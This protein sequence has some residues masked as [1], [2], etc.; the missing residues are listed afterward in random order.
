RRLEKRGIALSAG[1]LP[2]A[3]GGSSVTAGGP[4]T[5]LIECVMRAAHGHPTAAA[6]ALANGASTPMFARFKLLSGLALAAGLV[7][8]I[9]AQHPG[10]HAGPKPEQSKSA[11]TPEAKDTSAAKP[12]DTQPPEIAGRV[13]DSDGKPV[14][15]AKVYI[16]YYTPKALP[17][18]DRA[19]TD[20][21]GR[22]KF[23]LKA[24]D[25]DPTYSTTPWRGAFV[26]AKSDGYGVGW[27]QTDTKDD[28][29]SSKLSIQLP[30][31]APPLTG[32]FVNLEGKPIPGVKA[33]LIGVQQLLKGK[34]LGA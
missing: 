33:R 18:P 32:R 21:D 23:T 2:A 22:F 29:W 1:V 6:A 27:A 14:K 25:F 26:V 28:S 7:V 15:G 16:L 3:A 30:K 4:P 8:G 11:D 31:D 13:V 12:A 19:T 34:D 5:H 10:L 24:S 20:A 9:G 17:I